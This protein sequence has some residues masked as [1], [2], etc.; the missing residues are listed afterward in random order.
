VKARLLLACFAVAAALTAPVTAMADEP[1][2]SC[3]VSGVDYASGTVTFTVQF[4]PSTARIESY[5]DG[6]LLDRTAC[7]TGEREKSFGPHPLTAPKVMAFI[8]WTAAGA[9]AWE[10]TLAVDPRPYQPDKPHL[11]LPAGTVTGS[12]FTVSCDPS[13][14]VTS[15]RST[16]SGD[17]G[18]A[19]T[20]ASF[21]PTTYATVS[22]AACP[23]GRATFSLSVANGFGSSPAASVVVYNLGTRLPKK[24]RYVLVSKRILWMFYV[25]RGRVVKRWPVATGTPQT[26][27]PSGSFTIGRGRP[28]G[29]GWGVLRRRLYRDI[30]GRK[31]PPTRYYIHGTS[32]PW[33]IGTEASHGCV[34]M[35]NKHIREFSRTVP[36]G[37]FV[38][39]R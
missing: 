11:S 10:C 4:A 14:P 19:V 21:E 38:R 32:A 12:R 37:T 26:P 15:W 13:L 17:G 23:F 25:K 5:S 1:A 29:G 16:L 35:Y 30:K 27:T 34:R 3:S 36:T 18:S 7:G 28:A 8:G 33:S 20:T 2:A 22:R 31:N 24:S 9:R 6:V 39:I